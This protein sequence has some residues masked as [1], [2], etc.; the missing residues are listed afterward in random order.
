[1]SYT[2]NTA[3]EKRDVYER[4]T[5]QIINA[6]EQGVSNWRMRWHT[7]GNFAFWPIN[8]ISKKPYR[9][10][11]TV[12]LWASVVGGELQNRP[13]PRDVTMLHGQIFD[14][15]IRESIRWNHWKGAL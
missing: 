2:E 7:S 10:I 8:V 14:L 11:N 12:C 3:Q 4:V 15:Q 5:S 1:M 9:G 6:I 13:G